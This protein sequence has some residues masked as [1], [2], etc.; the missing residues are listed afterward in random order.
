MHCHVC[1]LLLFVGDVRS[2][3]VSDCGRYVIVAIRHGCDPVNRL[4]YCDL[5]QMPNGIQ[6]KSIAAVCV[7]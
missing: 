4:Y 2:A 5:S 1:Y 6:G 7:R 3:E